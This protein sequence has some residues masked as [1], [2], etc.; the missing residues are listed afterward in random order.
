MKE[1][2]IIQKLIFLIYLAAV[3]YLCL[4]HFSSIPKVP[5]MIW[6]IPTDKWAHFVMFF[7]FPVLFYWAFN[8]KTKKWWQS[9]LLTAGI[10]GIGAFVASG[11]EMLQGLTTYRTKD[12]L[13][14]H[15]DFIAMCISSAIVLVI[16]LIKTIKR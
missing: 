8:W 6:G 12:I 10:L 16:E 4:G 2:R 1:Y 3:A 11:T 7:P 5:R 15:A 14:F 9:V 13:D